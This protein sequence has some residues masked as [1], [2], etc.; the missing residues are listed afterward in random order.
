M[1][2]AVVREH[3]DRVASAYETNRLGGWYVAHGG[4]VADQLEGRRFGTAVDVGCG[5]GWLLREL[6]RRGLAER[7]IGLDLSSGMI[8]EA[9]ARAREDDL[10]RLEF[11][12]CD[13]PSLPGPLRERLLAARPEL[14]LFA[15]SLHYAT[16]LGASLARARELLAPG[17]LVA[18]LERA[19]ERSLLTR[20]WG[21][22]HRLLLRDGVE[23]MATPELLERLGE[24]GF[25]D[26]RV[27]AELKRWLW[28]GKVITSMALT[29]GRAG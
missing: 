18:I 22:T 25:R 28:R 15:S 16:D 12:Q 23:F 4:F 1:T 24:A 14:V 6:R 26:V 9:R 21:W 13:W 8:A 27:A 7:G 2:D 5:T 19:P 10:S 29:T 17:G 11:H 20:A 3:F